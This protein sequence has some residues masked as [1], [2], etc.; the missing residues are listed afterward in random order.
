LKGG[1]S[2]DLSIRH[3]IFQSGV[4]LVAFT[5]QLK[6]VSGFPVT[7]THVFTD[8]QLPRWVDVRFA[9]RYA[10]YVGVHQCRT[11]RT[12]EHTTEI[13]TEINNSDNNSNNNS[14]T[15]SRQ[16]HQH[17]TMEV[18]RKGGK[19]LCSPMEIAKI[20]LDHVYFTPALPAFPVAK[21]NHT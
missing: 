20:W 4:D 6:N 8:A 17:E 21:K 10:V 13:T 15:D 18:N 14:D 12:T 9:P 1:R 5:K 7:F 16:G 19:K 3:K 11:E 2:G